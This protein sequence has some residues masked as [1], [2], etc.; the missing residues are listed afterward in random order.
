MPRIQLSNG[1]LNVLDQGQGRI[2][3]LVHGFPLDH[4]MWSGQIED[5]SRSFRVLA[6]DLRGF[7]Q[8]SVTLGKVTMQQFADD[9]A[10]MLD[11]LRI[12]E[13]VTF[14][15][16]SMGG[17]IGWQ[18]FL[19]H[20]AKL[21]RLIQ[22]DTRAVADSPEARAGRL[23]AADEVEADGPAKLVAAMLPKLFAS[24]AI[25]A[26][27]EFVA[28][29]KHVALSNSPQGIAAAQRGMAERPDVS[30]ILPTIDVPALIVCGEHDA[31]AATQE[32]HGIAAD[33]PRAHYVEIPGAGHM[34][35]LED[36]AAFNAAVRQFLA[37]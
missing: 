28:A 1:S 17:Y 33:I 25:D 3:L 15:G 11:T 36:P 23:K 8:S 6:P 19:R 22:S 29:T 13:P 18:F 34:S 30:S 27:R 20:R 2:L 5:L 9:L 16:L 4:S 37:Q 12:A 14:C 24:P 26:G 35:P 7:G 32:M 10:A 31:I 21:D